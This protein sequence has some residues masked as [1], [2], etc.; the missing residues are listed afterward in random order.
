MARRQ[1]T[2]ADIALELGIS[3]ATVSRALK[4]YPDIS[5]KTKEKI[6][7]FHPLF[8]QFQANYKIQAARLHYDIYALTQRLRHTTMRAEHES[9]VCF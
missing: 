3:T 7:I 2:L 9:Q 1:I 8:S 5:K 4:D 6:I